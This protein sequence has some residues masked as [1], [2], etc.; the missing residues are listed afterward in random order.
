MGT[1]F[2][3]RKKEAKM[4]QEQLSKM[5]EQMDSAEVTGTAGGGLVTITLSGNH[6]MKS[7]KIKPDCV[8]KDDVEGLE[9]L[10]KTAYENALKELGS[11]AMPQ[12]PGFP[13]LPGMPF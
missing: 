8:D 10:I 13:G 6:T 7:I 2:A 11:N 5:K 12:I 9:L 3:K 1:G 4:M